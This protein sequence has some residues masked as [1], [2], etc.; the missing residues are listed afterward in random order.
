MVVGVKW[1]IRHPW[2]LLLSITDDLIA[3]LLFCKVFPSEIAKNPLTHAIAMGWGVYGVGVGEVLW[4]KKSSYLKCILSLSICHLPGGGGKRHEAD[5]NC[6][7]SRICCWLVRPWLWS[8]GLCDLDACDVWLSYCS[9][10]F[11]TVDLCM[12]SYRSGWND[13]KQLNENESEE[14]T[15]LNLLEKCR[16]FLLYWV[17]WR[18]LKE[19]S[20]NMN[21]ER[22]KWIK[23]T[24]Q[25]ER[26]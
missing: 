16:W 7:L 22:K 21:H 23:S 8:V 24:A 5:E 26:S 18:F 9:I 3:A 6:A 2:T 10:F 20:E 15:L 12:R 13:H 19:D 4:K 25:E 11:S 1:C 17:R 14:H